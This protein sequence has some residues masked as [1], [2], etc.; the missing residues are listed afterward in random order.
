[1]E[2]SHGALQLLG[3]ALTIETLEGTMNANIGDW[4]I[5]GV[6]GEFYPCTDEIFQL[7]YEKVDE[8]K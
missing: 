2:W 4:I 8:V 6:K 7:T 3:M 5:K 1:M